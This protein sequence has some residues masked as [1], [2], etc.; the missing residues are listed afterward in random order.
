[1]SIE[2]KKPLNA[3][4][5]LKPTPSEEEVDT[6]SGELYTRGGALKRKT[7]DPRVHHSLPA[8]GP[9]RDQLWSTRMESG[10]Q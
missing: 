8:L 3:L 7:M 2:Q 5:I 6:P 10:K 4:G 9:G 1:M